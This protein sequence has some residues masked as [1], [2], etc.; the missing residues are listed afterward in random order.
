MPRPRVFVTRHIFPE[1]LDAIRKKAQVDLWEDELPPSRATLLEKIKGVD[2]VLCLLTEV[3]DAEFMDAAGPQLKV[4]SQ[5]AVG[6]N[7]I[8][9][10][11]ATRRG[12][13]VGYTPD[14]LTQTTADFTFALLM[15]SARRVVEGHEFVRTGKWRTWHPL[16]FLGQDIYGAT[17]GIVG[18][19]RIGFEVARR[20][21]GFGMKVLYYDS[22]RKRELEVQVPMSP[23]DMDTLLHES[24][25]ITLHTALTKET[26]HLMSDAQ[27][28]KMKKTAILINAA[29][30][31]VVDPKALYRALK[32]GKIGGAALDVT[33]PEPIPVDDPLLKL[34]NCLIVPHIASASVAT[35]REMSRLAAQNLINGLEKRPLEKC[36]NPE[37]Y[38]K[39]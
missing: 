18:M 27:F 10:A 31:P 4:I 12:I 29:R 15:A 6:H 33:E 32:E 16:H 22:I 37:V 34:D 36:V 28:A 23:V 38:E 7:N 35:R 11:E 39:T 1:A 14:V 26:H 17:L 19:G 13:P 25:F 9:V 5:I 8:D 20:A 2:G 21:T 24:D 30:G 3:V